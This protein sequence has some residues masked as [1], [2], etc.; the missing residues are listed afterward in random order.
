MSDQSTLELFLL[1]LISRGVSTP[2]E[3][4]AQAGLSVGA[5]KPALERLLQ[6]GLIKKGEKG[7][8]SRVEYLLTSAGRRA[9]NGCR[10]RSA[11]SW[12]RLHQMWTPFCAFPS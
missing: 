3:F 9:V 8:R 5:T 4:K 12:L 10:P 6:N 11:N 2:Y 1:A 7:S